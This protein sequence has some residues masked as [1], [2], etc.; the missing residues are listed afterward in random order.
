[1]SRTGLNPKD[2]FGI[3][4]PSLSC[5][6]ASVLMEVAVGMQEGA[7]KYGRSNY[8]SIAV[9]AS[10]YYD[11]TFRHLAAWWEG[12]DIDPDSGL[13][14]V[15]KAIASLVVL[16][17]AMMQQN[18]HDDRPPKSLQW[19]PQLTEVSQKL[20]DKYPNPVVPY[21]EIDFSAEREEK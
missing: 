5:V 19:L 2:A 7:A 12:E 4:K 11:A 10:I 6:P 21:T 1:M 8:R 9:R 20:F 16:R 3:K 14:H 17:D 13:S 18:W 15:T